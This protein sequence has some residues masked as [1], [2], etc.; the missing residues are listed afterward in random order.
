[1][2]DNSEIRVKHILLK[3]TGS[4]NPFDSYRKKP[5]TRSKED[6]IKGIQGNIQLYC[7]Y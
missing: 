2:V 4:R 5:I 1:M 7:V 6:A 3:H